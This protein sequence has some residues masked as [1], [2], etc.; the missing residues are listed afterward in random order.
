MLARRASCGRFLED[1]HG[2]DWEE[3][4]QFSLLCAKLRGESQKFEC[5]Q[6]KLH[7]P[8]QLGRRGLGTAKRQRTQERTQDRGTAVMAEKQSTV[9][10]RCLEVGRRERLGQ[11]KKNYG[12]LGG[13]ML[14]R[15]WTPPPTTVPLEDIALQRG[16]GGFECKR[17]GL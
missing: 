2:G 15:S 9:L 10:G 8:Q 13:G 14:E 7:S 17:P 4:P 11:A 6:I 1:G 12:Q 3:G 5:C 16:R